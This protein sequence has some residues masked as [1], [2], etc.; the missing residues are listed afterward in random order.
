M[1]LLRGIDGGGDEQEPRPQ[2]FDLETEAE[3][4]ELSLG[5]S[6]GGR[7]GPDRTRLPRSSSVACILAPEEAPPAALPRTSSLP[8]MADADADAGGKLGTGGSNVAR[9]DGAE[10]EP[11]A[12]LQG[13]AVAVEHSATLQGSAVAVEPAATLQGSAVE[14][15]PTATQQ[16]SAV[17]VEPSATQQVSAVAVEPTATQQGSA[18]A[19]GPAAKL[20]A[21]GSPSTGSSDG[22]GKGH[23]GNTADVLPR[24]S[25]LPAGIEDEWRKRKEAQTLKRLEVKRKRIERRN[26]SNVS[27]EAVGHILEEMNATAS[28]DR[29]ESSD[30]PS[31]RNKQ[32]EGNESHSKV[33]RR[34]SG[35][36][37]TYQATVASQGSCLPGKLKRHNSAM[38][39]TPSAEEQSL[40]PAVLPSSEG[41]KGILPAQSANNTVMA[42]PSSSA[43]AVRAAALGSRGEHQP[44]SG[45]LA[46]RARSMG[47]VERVM[48][49]EM[50]CVCTKGLPNG[51]KIEGFLYKYRRAEE[52]RIVCVC[53]GSF[54]TPAEFVKHAGGGEVANPLRH[55]VVNPVAHSLS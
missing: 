46:A 18:V 33:R 36:P 10:V 41:T 35:L 6:L 14:V 30:D 53:H 17:E 26:S 19:V 24:T 49:Q 40:S 3:E 37:P 25:S 13:S 29:V 7:F 2:R 42:T 55:I 39:G 4:V 51:R 43:L 31:M 20:P 47:D 32:T 12:N 5:L 38:K 23:E 9:A 50:P 16:M 48:M 34:S 1:D 27:A 22:E 54:L 15:V 21:T 8:T 52:V 44:A 28:A 45:R 11:S